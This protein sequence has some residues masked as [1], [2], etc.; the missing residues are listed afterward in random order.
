MAMSLV[1]AFWLAALAKLRATIW[2]GSIAQRWAA[3]AAIF[4][5]QK[6]EERRRREQLR[7]T[8]ADLISRL[9][10]Q[11]DDESLRRQLVQ[12]LLT[13]EL[14]E[15]QKLHADC[16]RVADGRARGRRGKHPVSSRDA[17]WDLT[18]LLK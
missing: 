6:R 8:Y 17:L 2:R 14:S 3:F 10:H 11:G 9:M 12:R 4:S 5:F 7:R 18:P 15:L 1:Q 16:L 13:I